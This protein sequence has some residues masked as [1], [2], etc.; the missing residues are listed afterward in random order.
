MIKSS[1]PG[2]NVR[3][4]AGDIFTGIFMKENFC[5]LLRIS[6]TFLPKGPAGNKSMLVQVM[7]W[8]WTGDKPLYEPMP[9]QFIES[10]MRQ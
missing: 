8:R 2:Q 4:F 7:A 9:T 6:G 3:H 10:Y 1:I 5:I